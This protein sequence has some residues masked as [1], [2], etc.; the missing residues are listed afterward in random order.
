[1]D[2][3]GLGWG[4]H[5]SGGQRVAR[6][7]DWGCARRLAA[8]AGGARH[9]LARRPPLPPRQVGEF[10]VGQAGPSVMAGYWS[11]ADTGRFAPVAARPAD[12]RMMR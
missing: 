1:M 4:V 10:A 6:L 7:W 8:A 12:S 2:E 3:D 9:G 11:N 5:W